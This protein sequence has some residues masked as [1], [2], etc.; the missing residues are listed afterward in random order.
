MNK[1]NTTQYSILGA[2]SIEPMSGYEIKKL[3]AESTNYFWAE[4]NGQLYPTL[5][6]LAKSKLVTVKEQV[7]GKKTSKIYTLTKAG[8]K[9]LKEWLVKEAN[10]FP[11]RDVL[12]LKLF[13]GSN[14]PPE[15]SI[16]H[17]NNHV[18]KCK[19]ALDIYTDI[20][21][22]LEEFV[23]QKKYP[24]YYLLTVK[25]GIQRVQAELEWSKEAIKL[26]YKYSE[27]KNI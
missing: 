17:I 19:S 8:E 9:K 12:L 5:A 25:A 11:R 6:K 3:M 24:V 2:L 27:I 15:V 23:K 1:S 16:K 14:V 26:I 22:K 18:K 7:I 20:A 4:S 21:N 10:P 13:Y